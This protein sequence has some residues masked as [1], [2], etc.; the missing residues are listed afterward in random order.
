[1][2]QKIDPTGTPIMPPFVGASLVDGEDVGS[3]GPASALAAAPAPTSPAPETDNEIRASIVA[4]LAPLDR[5]NLL[6]V[7]RV[8]AELPFE[9]LVRRCED[10]TREGVEPLGATNFRTGPTPPLMDMRARLLDA[11]DAARPFVGLAR[12]VR[13]GVGK[14]L[15]PAVEKDGAS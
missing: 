9:L 1:M 6:L 10:A 2:T 12:R 7:R 14:Y 13:E 15:R 11:L 5:D 4:R 3:R 8:L